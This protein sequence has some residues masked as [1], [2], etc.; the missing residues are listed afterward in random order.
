VNALKTF[1][2]AFVAM[3]ALIGGL[4]LVAAI[5]VGIATETHAPAWLLVCLA[6]CAVGAGVITYTQHGKD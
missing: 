3:A 4:T 5:V 1:A 6:A 2:A